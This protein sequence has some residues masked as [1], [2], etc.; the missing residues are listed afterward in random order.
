MQPRRI[1]IKNS[2]REAWFHCWSVNSEEAE[3][4]YGN[5][6]VAIVE[7]DD[8]TVDTVFA[9]LVRFLV[10]YGQMKAEAERRGP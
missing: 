10:P 4:S 3:S 1:H 6:P 9:E 2:E 7:Y 5:F 8:G